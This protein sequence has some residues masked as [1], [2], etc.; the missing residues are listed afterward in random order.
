MNPKADIF[1]V[2]KSTEISA[3]VIIRY[4]RDGKIKIR[5]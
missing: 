4:V 5:W 1:T 2:S 3:S